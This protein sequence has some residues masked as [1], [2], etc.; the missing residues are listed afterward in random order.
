MS[1]KQGSRLIR[2]LPALYREHPFLEEFLLAFEKVIYDGW[3]SGDSKIGY[4]AGFDKILNEIDRYFIPS[5]PDPVDDYYQ[6]DGEF[7]QWLAQWVD[8]D[9]DGEWPEKDRRKNIALAMD[10]YRRRG[11]VK[12]LKEYLKIYTGVEPEIRECC[13]P[14][15]MQ[16]GV[17]ST[18][19]GM[20][21]ENGMA[22]IIT[23]EHRTAGPYDYYVISE[24]GA[25]GT[26]TYY[27]RVDKV[28][29]IDLSLKDNC[30]I[31]DYVSPDGEMNRATHQNARATRRDGLVDNFYEL[32]G[33]PAS[34]GIDTTITY[35]GD[36]VLIDEERD[37]PFRFIIDVKVPLYKFSDKKADEILA[38]KIRAIVNLEK[39]AHTIYYL[40]L[41]P[42]R[43]ATA[44]Q[45]EVRSTIAIDTLIG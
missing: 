42:V 3:E 8:L 43:A 29:K 4:V 5:A 23:T 35:T 28:R 7:L 9:L 16:I 36:T 6:T 26:V 37:I 12:G 38:D 18:I 40:R 25:S 2:Y 44:M 24:Q 14:A 32:T 19:G 20:A 15:G 31:I 27:Y 41:T 17:T 33:S 13:W 39:P 22:K 30:V 1:G 11:T 45:I 10:L 34:G 21:P